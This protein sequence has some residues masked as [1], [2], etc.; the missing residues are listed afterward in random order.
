MAHGVVTTYKG[1]GIRVKAANFEDAAKQLRP[2]DYKRLLGEKYE[3]SGLPMATGKDA[4]TEFVDG[5]DVVPLYSFRQ[6]F[7]RTWVVRATKAPAIKVVQH[8]Y[9]LAVIKDAQPRKSGTT[10]RE[11]WCPPHPN[12][13]QQ[14]SSQQTWAQIV[15]G[16]EGDKRNCANSSPAAPTQTPVPL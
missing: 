3:I 8:D 11:R 10:Q 12:Q 16:H 7:C 14:P 6:G 5:W 13:Q 2:E 15:A 4:L 9:G 1:L